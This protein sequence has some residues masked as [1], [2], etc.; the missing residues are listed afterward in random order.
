M[1]NEKNITSLLVDGVIKYCKENGAK[2]LRFFVEL[3]ESMENEW[4][5]KIYTVVLNK[6]EEYQVYSSLNVPKKDLRLSPQDVAGH[7]RVELQNLNYY[8][9]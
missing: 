2:P 5:W 8:Y 7:I 9:G 6:E 4:G 3:D 1:T